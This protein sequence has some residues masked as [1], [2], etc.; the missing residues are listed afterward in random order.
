MFAFAIR[1]L[2]PSEPWR[3]AVHG[4]PQRLEF[5]FSQ[6]HGQNAT[7]L[8]APSTTLV[9]ACDEFLRIFGFFRFQA[10]PITLTF[11]SSPARLIVSITS[12][13]TIPHGPCHVCS[14]AQIRN[15]HLDEEVESLKG[16]K[17]SP[18]D[19]GIFLPQIAP[20]DHFFS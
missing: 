10:T 7:A 4:F 5:G 3:T 8:G 11:R 17:R 6:G 19:P 20:Q 9:R 14:I 15:Y 12:D 13:L 18:C 2:R 1:V 16:T